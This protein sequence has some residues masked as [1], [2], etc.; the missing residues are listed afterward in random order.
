MGIKRHKPDEI[1]TK[2]RQVK[3]WFVTGG[4][5]PA[6]GIANIA[7]YREAYPWIDIGVVADAGQ[8]LIYQRY[9]APILR[10]AAAPKTA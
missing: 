9:E 1:V 10:I 8:M 3:T 6:T 5:G 7:E 2:L 4:Q